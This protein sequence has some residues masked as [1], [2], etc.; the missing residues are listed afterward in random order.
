MRLLILTGAAA[1][2]F[3]GTQVPVVAQTTKA[4]VYK[5]CLQEMGG[6]QG[7]GQTLCRYTSLEQCW[8]SKT[9]SGDLCYVNTDYYRK[10]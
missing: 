4:P 6:I 3:V 2:I 10:K 5:Y 1:L 9:G 7:T 8:A